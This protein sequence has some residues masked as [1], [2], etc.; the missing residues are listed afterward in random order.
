[1]ADIATGLQM[2][3]FDL[4][5]DGGRRIRL[6]DL[7]GRPFVMFFY[8]RDD[9]P[10]CT[11]EAADFSALRADFAGLGAAVVGV[12]PDTPRKH[13]NYKK[14]HG[15]AVDL[16]SDV[17]RSLIGPMGLWVEKMMYGRKYMGVERTT[18]LVDADGTIIRVWPK[19]SVP[20]HAAEV[21]EALRTHLHG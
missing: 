14:K 16:L 21:L 4:P 10:T 9:T 1:M 8:P 17:E 15:L 20:G 3:D 11:V 18:V 7:H 12:S 13:D 5:A 2:P 6:A 19:V